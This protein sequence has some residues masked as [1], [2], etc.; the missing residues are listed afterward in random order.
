MAVINGRCY[1]I[2]AA[3]LDHQS[4]PT[5]V[6]SSDNLASPH[7]LDV[8][9]S[10]IKPQEVKSLSSQSLID[11]SQASPYFAYKSSGE[12]T[13]S[14]IG[15]LNGVSIGTQTLAIDTDSE[16]YSPEPLIERTKTAE[17]WT[18]TILNQ[19]NCELQII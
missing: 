6:Q 17:A 2:P 3:I 9:V 4:I 5:S 15:R 14:G 11:V 19:Q 7:G 12:T 18:Q 10:Q 1:H 16:N 8:T 13:P